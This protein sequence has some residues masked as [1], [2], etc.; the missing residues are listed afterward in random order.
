MSQQPFLTSNALKLSQPNLP[1]RHSD[2]QVEMISHHAKSQ[3]LN[4]TKP[5]LF[6]NQLHESLLFH[7]IKKDR[8]AASATHE[9]IAMSHL[10][11]LS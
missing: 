3:H 8:P 9:V 2:Q 6:S 11:F 4:P 10:P 1:I 7:L 5:S